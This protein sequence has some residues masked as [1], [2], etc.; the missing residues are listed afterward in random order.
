MPITIPEREIVAVVPFTSTAADPIDGSTTVAPPAPSS[1][2]W[3]A[4]MQAF[5]E[6]SIVNS[7]EAPLA[8]KT[9][10]SELPYSQPVPPNLTVVVPSGAVAD[11]VV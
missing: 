4:L 7:S 11:C 8:V 9:P 1:R 3:M 10:T 6:Y 5:P 2:T